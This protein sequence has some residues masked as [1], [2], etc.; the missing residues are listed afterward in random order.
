MSTGCPQSCPRVDVVSCLV[1]SCLFVRVDFSKKT[2][3]GIFAVDCIQ[4]YNA[5]PAGVTSTDGALTEVA[6]TEATWLPLKVSVGS[7]PFKQ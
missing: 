6:F 4:Q 5:R 7:I 2:V 1:V 3:A